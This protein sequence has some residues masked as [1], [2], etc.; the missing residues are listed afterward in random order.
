MDDRLD[1]LALEQG[2]DQFPVPHPALHERRSAGDSGAMPRAEVIE[3]GDREAPV[4]QLIY[5]DT[6]D[7]PRAS[8]H[9]NSGH[10]GGS[11][12]NS[13]RSASSKPYP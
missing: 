1:P 6:P 11:S 12:P 7:V 2:G 4:Q 5:D 9:K 3:H 10:A 8:R 13:R